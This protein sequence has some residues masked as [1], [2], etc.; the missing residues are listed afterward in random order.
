MKLEAHIRVPSPTAG[1]VTG[2]GSKTVNEPQ[3][4]TSAEVIVPH[5]NEE[6]IVRIIG[7]FFA[8]QTAQHKIRE[9]VQQVKQQE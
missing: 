4:L 1:Q 5:E 7:H 3:N 9:T 6:V 2:K 8:S